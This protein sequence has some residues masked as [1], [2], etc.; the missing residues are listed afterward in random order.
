MDLEAF[1]GNCRRAK[2]LTKGAVDQIKY[3]YWLYASSLRLFR[4]QSLVIRF[5][6]PPPVNNLTLTVRCNG[7]SDAFIF[8]EVFQH[9]YYKFHLEREPQSILDAGGN[10]GLTAIYFSKAYPGAKIACV[11]PIP[12]NLAILRQNVSINGADVEVFANAL[13]ISNRPIKME[14]AGKDYG[15][16]VRDDT[17]VSD[18]GS[19]ELIVPGITVPTIMERMGWRTID[20][21]KVDIEGYESMLLGSDCDWL[22]AVQA[23]CIE[24][25]EGFDEHQLRRVTTRHGLM[26]LNYLDGVWLA[27]R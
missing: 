24:L 27:T 14:Y 19:Q 3:L 15:H 8:S 1:I 17:S 2:R 25:H 9:S 26:R 5:S 21:L 13:S 16:R 11:E 7:G 18:F 6:L 10:I 23:L 20:L 12:E 4:R 22:D